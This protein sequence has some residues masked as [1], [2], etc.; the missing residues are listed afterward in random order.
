MPKEKTICLYKNGKVRWIAEFDFLIDKNTPRG[1]PANLYERKPYGGKRLLGDGEALGRLRNG[2]F[3]IDNCL[4]TLERLKVISELGVSVSTSHL[5]H[6]GR[7]L[8]TI[9]QPFKTLKQAL[10]SSKRA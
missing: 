10:R 8:T 6:N 5:F 9:K 3:E 2:L 1:D 4:M 7:V